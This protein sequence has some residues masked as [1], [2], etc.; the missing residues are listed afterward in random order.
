LQA[1][2]LWLSSVESFDPL[3]ALREIDQHATSVDRST[4]GALVRTIAAKAIGTAAERPE[5]AAIVADV[6]DKK[7]SR[8]WGLINARNDVIH[9]RRPA[10][11]IVPYADAVADL[12]RSPAQVSDLGRDQRP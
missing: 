10:E 6:A 9:G 5:I 11:A 2:L 7:A 8:I 12:L 4:A 3:V 1:S